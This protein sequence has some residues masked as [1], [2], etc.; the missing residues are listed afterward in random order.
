[1]S[2]VSIRSVGA[3][4]PPPSVDNE[5]FDLTSYVATGAILECRPSSVFDTRSVVQD[6]RHCLR[7]LA[8]SLDHTA[9]YICNIVILERRSV[10][11]YLY[12]RRWYLRTAAHE[13]CKNCKLA[14]MAH[15]DSGKC[16]YD[17]TH[18]ERSL[19]TPIH[20]FDINTGHWLPAHEDRNGI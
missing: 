15:L 20:Y 9:W 1:M 11:G 6:S 19:T 16:L 14:Y 5:S 17:V 10:Y 2:S 8:G 18:F 3:I 12:Q 13:R 7:T 4:P